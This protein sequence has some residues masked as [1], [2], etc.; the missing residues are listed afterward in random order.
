MLLR[1]GPLTSAIPKGSV[2]FAA[3]FRALRLVF[4]ALW[5]EAE[6]AMA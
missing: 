5:P 2:G 1:H 3:H 6:A 4:P